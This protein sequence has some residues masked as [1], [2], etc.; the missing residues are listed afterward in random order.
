MTAREG[1]LIENLDECIF[2]VKGLIHPPNRVIAFI[3][4]VPDANGNRERD[5]F[6]AWKR[7]NLWSYGPTPSHAGVF[8][9]S[10]K[11]PEYVAA[12]VGVNAF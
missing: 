12:S 8:A 7:M 4:Y 3:R 9:H 11:E 5:G 1:D 2:D 10:I 6:R